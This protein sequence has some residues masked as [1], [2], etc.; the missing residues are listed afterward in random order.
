MATEEI[1]NVRTPDTKPF[2]TDKRQLDFKK[3][4]EDMLDDKYYKQSYLLYNKCIDEST[5]FY[6]ASLNKLLDEDAEALDKM[7]ADYGEAL[8]KLV[9]N[10]CQKLG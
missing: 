3:Y 8:S 9:N 4:W 7:G 1:K 5:K 10:R 2:T 6:A